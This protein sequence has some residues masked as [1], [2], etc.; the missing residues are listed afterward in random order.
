MKNIQFQQAPSVPTPNSLKIS[1]PATNKN[2]IQ[3]LFP[4]YFALVMATGII[5]IAA[6]SLQMTSVAYFLFWLNVGFY[7]VLLTLLLLRLLFYFSHLVT[8]LT[9]HQNSPGFLTLVAG[10]CILGTQGLVLY[11]NILMAEILLAFG[12]VGWCIIIYTFLTIITV[13]RHKPSIEKGINGAWLITIV[14]TQSIAILSALI[15]P[16]TTAGEDVIFFFSL[17]MYFVGCFLY[18]IINALIFYRFSFFT[19]QPKELSAP[20]WINVGAAAITT[21]AGSTLMLSGA[22]WAFM[23]SILPFMKGFTLFFWSASSWWIPLFLILGF[24][25]HFAKKVPL[26]FSNSGYH[27]SYWSMVFPLGMY[28][29]CTFKLSEALGLQFLKSIPE[30]F[31]YIAFASWIMVFAGLIHTLAIR[32]IHAPN[33]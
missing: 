30:Y 25:R 3:N 2:I 22:E 26:P 28:T 17:Y 27:P 33:E 9:D 8:D 14:A 4:G 19:F 20:Y 23:P 5:S 29:A 10:S 24:W 12:A 32:L 7:G 18:I 31:I 1:D 11:E 15:A 16:T 13:K 6:H 21:L